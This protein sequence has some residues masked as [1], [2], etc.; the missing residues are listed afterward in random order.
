[1]ARPSKTDELQRLLALG[2]EGDLQPAERD[3]LAAM[4]A[5]DDEAQEAAIA[6]LLNDSLLSSSLSHVDALDRQ[7]ILAQ[8]SQSVPEPAVSP[9]ADAAA[10]HDQH[11]SAT[12][13]QSI[14]ERSLVWR[15]RMLWPIATLAA[16][17]ALVVSN[18][19]LLRELHKGEEESLPVTSIARLS[20]STQCLWDGDIPAVP[21]NRQELKLNRS[22]RLLEGIAE[23]EL[24]YVQAGDASVHVE[25]PAGWLITDTGQPCLSYGK[26]TVNSS[27]GSHIRSI[28][29]PMGRVSFEGYTSL[30]V[31]YFGS[32]LE[33]HAFSG[34]ATL[35][36]LWFEKNPFGPNCYIESPT[37]TIDSGQMM[38][39][40]IRDNAPAKVT[41]GLADPSRFASMLSMAADSIHFDA[42]YE[43]AVRRDDPLAYWRFDHIDDKTIP[44]EMGD[45][46]D[47]R[48]VGEVETQGDRHNRYLVFGE[49][50]DPA[51]VDAAIVTDTSF[52][53]R[54]S[55]NCTVEVW[56]K[57]SH[58]QQA[59]IIGLV[60]GPNDDDM[61][62]RHG[63]LLELTGPR[64]VAVTAAYPGR[65]RFLNRFP[66]DLSPKSLDESSFSSEVY[67]LRRWQHLVAVKDEDERRLYIN[68]QLESREHDTR[69][70]DDDLTLILG[71]LHRDRP[72]RSFV[73][74][75][76]ELAVYDYPLSEQ[77]IRRHHELVR[78]V[79]SVQ[80]GI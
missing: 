66:A 23:V 58:Y 70:I 48:I 60:K 2:V 47:A 32:E 25:G 63:L 62:A 31:M 38:R 51:H 28:D 9:S 69:P 1:M 53:Q 3:R 78:S 55:R 42:K 61:R 68:G 73:G 75:L 37:Q 44:N 80:K 15:P 77:Q 36:S 11:R 18:V 50:L 12:S 74:Q 7:S 20:E 76:D 5:T 13:S 59:S 56:V 27:S 65:V 16:V 33:I 40:S 34:A 6:Y 26:M 64:A 45:E 39:I 24:S 21:G 29:T 8:F 49:S 52:G 30:G 54:L 35:D 19:F 46:F 57:P 79:P 43:R 10:P 14:L 22:L 67:M 41:R 4:L 17:I 71:R 72:E